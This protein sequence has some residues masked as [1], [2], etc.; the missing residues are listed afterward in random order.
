MGIKILR[1]TLDDYSVVESVIEKAFKDAEH[2]DHSEQFLVQR[3]RKSEEFIKELSL[4]AVNEKEIVGYAMFTKMIIKNDNKEVESLALAPV[5]VLPEYQFKGIGSKL[6]ERG[7]DIAKDLGFQS[8]I[9]LGHDKYYPRFGFEK[10]SNYKIKAPFEVPD[11]AFM[12]LELEKNSLE[13]VS[14]VVEYSK[15]F[16]E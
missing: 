2:T 14:G 8:V 12:A 7:L 6:I 15:A 1:E 4:V 11:S 10:A 9:V 5:A 13:S 16:F 3:L